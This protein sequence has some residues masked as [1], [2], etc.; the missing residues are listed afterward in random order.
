MKSQC[1][2]CRIIKGEEPAKIIHED[3]KFI[4][5]LTPFPNT[6]GFTVVATKEH[7]TSYIFQLPQDVYLPFLLFARDVGLILDQALDVYRTGLI[8]EGMGIDHAHMKLVPLH[9]VKKESWEPV[10][11]NYPIFYEKYPGFIASH[12]G[13]RQ[14]EER[15]NAIYETVM[16]KKPN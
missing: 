13:P 10:H 15:L 6:D 2:F 16:L 14:E 12:D 4:A 8:F 9:G 11:S 5:F 7:L 3:E 1:I